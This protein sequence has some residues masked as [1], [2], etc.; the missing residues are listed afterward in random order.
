MLENVEV[1]EELKMILVMDTGNTNI[2][3]GVYDQGQLKYHWRMETYRQKTE[4]EYAMQVKSLFTHVG[5]TFEEVTW[6][7]HFICCATG[8]VSA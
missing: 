6:N 7:Y 4:D 2:V 3:L 1:S 8:N 5:L